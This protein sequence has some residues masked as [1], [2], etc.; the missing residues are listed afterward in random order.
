MKQGTVLAGICKKTENSS[1]RTKTTTGESLFR[2]TNLV[3]IKMEDSRKGVISGGGGVNL[4]DTDNAFRNLAD[5]K[6]PRGGRNNRDA[7]EFGS[8][9]SR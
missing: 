7:N 1:L 8:R 6:G 5:W 9:L 3:L 4:K 2:R